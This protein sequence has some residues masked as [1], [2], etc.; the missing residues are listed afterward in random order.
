MKNFRLTMVLVLLVCLF[1]PSLAFS[2]SS[3]SGNRTYNIGDIGP[4]G[5]IIFYDRGFVSDGWRYLEAAP[6]STEFFGVE[7]GAYEQDVFGTST[8][9]GSGR[10]NT[11]LIVT[12]LNSR[13]KSNCAAQRCAALNING[14][15]DW[16]L[17]SK[18]ELNLMYVNLLQRGL[19]GFNTA[20]D[21]TNWTHIYWSSSQSSTA[22]S[23]VQLFDDGYQVD[24]NGKYNVFS[25]RAVRAF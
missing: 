25:V 13:G 23:W 1:A 17:P 24:G 21:T 14:F 8:A 2:Q 7:W 16:F 19:G 6:A 20:A 18:D 4:A 5:G 15:T 3:A 22:Y 9:V 10:L 12:H 11:Q